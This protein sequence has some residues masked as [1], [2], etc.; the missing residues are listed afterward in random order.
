MSSLTRPKSELDRAFMPVLVTSNFDDD[1]IKNERASMETPFSHY[2]T[3]G[4]FLEV[5]GS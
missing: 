3:M 4:N 1:L 5:K 2:K